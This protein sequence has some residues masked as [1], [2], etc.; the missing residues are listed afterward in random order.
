M[1]GFRRPLGER[2]ATWVGARLVGAAVFVDAESGSRDEHVTL[3]ELSV[4]PVAGL[5][6]RLGRWF[7]LGFTAHLGY[8]AVSHRLSIEE[9]EVLRGG[10]I[11]FGGSL[12][13]SVVLW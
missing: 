4:G 1:A 11:E 5:S 12:L 2:L 8:L 9:R 7:S 6:Y 10:R 3:Y 13:A